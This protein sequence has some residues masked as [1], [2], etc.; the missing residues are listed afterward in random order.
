LRDALSIFDLIVTFSSDNNIT[1]Q[2]TIS[3]LHVLDYDYYFR[4]CDHFLEENTSAVLLLFDEILRK[5]FDGH[6]FIN[7]LQQHL[8]N[9]MVCKDPST[10][11][12]LDVS[13]NIQKKYQDQAQKLSSSYLLS[14]LNLLSQTDVTY[15]ASKNQRLHVELAIMK[16]THLNQAINFASDPVGVKK[17]VV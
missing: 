14:G 16:L 8:R 6:N 15:K 4:A 10:L 7:G 11:Q 12:L 5:G 3:N 1:Y 9:L 17:K 13:E 2:N